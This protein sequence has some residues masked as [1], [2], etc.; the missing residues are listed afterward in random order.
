MKTDFLKQIPKHLNF[1]AQSAINSYALV[2]FSN[3]KFFGV[4]LLLVSFMDVWAGLS[5][6]ISVLAVNVLAIYLGYSPYRINNGYYGYNS[7]LVGLGIGLTFIP[8]PEFYTVILVAAIFTFFVSIVLEG[9]LAKY[10]LPFISIP[11]IIS[12]WIVVLASRDLSVLGLSG[13]GIFTTNELYLLGGKRLADFYIWC[14]HLDLP[15]IVQTYFLALGAIFFQYNLPAGYLIAFGLFFYSRISFILSILGFSIA[16]YFYVFVGANIAMYGYSFIGFNYILTAIALGGHFL[17]PSRHSFIWVIVLL[18][19]VVLLS[20]GLGRFLAPYQL[21][22]Y[23]L[24]FNIIVLLF[25]YSLKLRLLP[26]KHLG[27]VILQLYSP[28]KNLYFN[29]QARSRF[30]WLE[31]YPISLP[32]HGEW[33]ISQAHNGEIT[34]KGEWA[35]A[36]DFIIVDKQG[37]QFKDEGDRP[38][39]YYCYGKLVVAPAYGYVVDI[40]DGIE[41]NRIGQVNIIHNWGNSIVIKHSEYLY[42]QISHLKPGSFK[43]KKGDYVKKGDTLALCGNSGRSPYPHLHFQLQATPF[44][45]SRTLDYP[46][47]HFISQ[48]EGRYKLKSYSRP[49]NG[50]VVSNIAIEPILK[51]ALDFIPGQELHFSFKDNT[52]REMLLT[53]QIQA[54]VYN[55]PFIYCEKTKSYAYFFNDGSLL[56]FKNFVGSKKSGLYQ[57]YLSLY[58]IPFGFYK[59]MQVFD[60]YPANLVYNKYLMSIQ[61]IVAPFYLFLKSQFVMEYK[62]ADNDLSP[63]EI[64]LE[65]SMATSFIG[66]KKIIN[67]NIV[68]NKRGI[69]E[70]KSNEFLLNRMDK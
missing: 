23:S 29:E 16:Y 47:D 63:S 2:F 59:G 14:S 3:N 32:F 39:D 64:E 19:V 37:K 24:P 10:Y 58:N 5:G 69:S 57:F 45:G 25:L 4:I 22:I 42:S 6:L 43:V 46:I 52:N 15:H 61:D 40:A 35:H 41:D 8:G 48:N 53:W 44:I 38:E 31:F 62:K 33:T 1:H 20:L 68:I 12:L 18:P 49:E 13:R 11:F 34:H 50:E 36:Y 7:L 9:I 65:S 60:S 67:F 66:K 55:N 27:E 51:N 28:E 30:K 26:K 21:S 56:Y 17:V 70:I 54:D